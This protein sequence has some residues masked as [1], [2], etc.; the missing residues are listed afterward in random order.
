MGLLGGSS[1]KQSGAN[2]VSGVGTFAPKNNITINEPLLDFKNPFELFA[3][4]LICAAG[5]CAWRKFK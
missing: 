1:S 2:S 4:A 3:I 5:W